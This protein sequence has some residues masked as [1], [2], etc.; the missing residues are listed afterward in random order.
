MAGT[1]TIGIPYPQSTDNND[2]PTHILNLANWLDPVIEGSYTSAEITAF[3]ATQKWTSRRVYNS[4][5]GCYQWYNGSAW[6]NEQALVMN[7]Q[8]GTTY[9]LALTDANNKMVTLNNAGA[10]TLTIPAN[11]SIAFPVGTVI[12][13]MAKGAGQVTVAITTDTLRATPGTKLRAQYSVATLVKIAS[14]EWVLT[15]DVVA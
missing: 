3:T 8:V 9:T 6:L 7:D 13:L 1:T 12:T 14:T 2:V 5:L 4:T 15:G 10:I 11:G